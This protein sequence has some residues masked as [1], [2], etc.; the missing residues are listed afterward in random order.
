MSETS[1]TDFSGKSILI[2][3]D[4]PLLHSLLAD[5][6]KQL[7]D[8]GVKVFPTMSAEE[9]LKQA[10]ESKPDLI[11]LD[12]VLPTMDGFEFLQR[13]RAIPGFE[14]TPVVVL[15]N[16]SADT[17]KE[18]ARSLGVIAYMVKADFSLSEISAAVEQI[19]QGKQVSP[20]KPADGTLTKTPLGY[21]TY[22]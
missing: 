17:D 3:E 4:D 7:R 14:K 19:L 16:L 11:M 8:K 1:A 12:L 9:G 2:I 18:R 10:Q 15:S 21:M 22:L 6:M 5:K 13:L 20:P